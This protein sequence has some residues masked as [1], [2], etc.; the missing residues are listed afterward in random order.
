MRKIPLNSAFITFRT[1]C[2]SGLLRKEGRA[3]VV[4]DLRALEA[5]VYEVRGSA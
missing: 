5:L 4:S 3:L 2:R 1:F